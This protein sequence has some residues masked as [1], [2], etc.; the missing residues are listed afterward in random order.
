MITRVPNY[1][2]MGRGFVGF[3]RVTTALIRDEHSCTWEIWAYYPTNAF[4][5]K[6]NGGTAP[7][8]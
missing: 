8:D 3:D 6:T 1:S 5:G 2:F 7:L 4:E